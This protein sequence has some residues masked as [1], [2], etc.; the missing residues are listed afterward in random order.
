MF[1][2]FQGGFPVSELGGLPG[3]PYGFCG[4]HIFRDSN[5]GV[6]L[7]KSMGPFRGPMSLG[8][9]ENHTHTHTHTGKTPRFLVQFMWRFSKLFRVQLLWITLD[10]QQTQDFMRWTPLVYTPPKINGCNQ[11]MMGKPSSE[12]PGFQGTQFSWDSWDG[13]MQK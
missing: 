9:P 1:G 8:V 10:Y 12:S 4:T 11:K 2:E 6:G 5:M 3:T 7:G 13:T